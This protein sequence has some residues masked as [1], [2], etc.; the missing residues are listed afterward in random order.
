[1]Q[2]GEIEKDSFW[3]KDSLP[4][5]PQLDTSVKVD[6]IIVGGGIA[7]LH[8][9]YLLKQQGKRVAVI[10]A[11]KIAAGVSG[12]TTAHITS[13]HNLIY[14]Y[15]IE[16]FG[17]DKARTYATANQHALARIAEIITTEEIDCDF[18]RSSQILLT[19]KKSDVEILKKEFD[20]A[21]SLGLPVTY[22]DLVELPFKHY[23][24]IKYQHQ[25]RFHPVK[26]L[27]AIAKKINGDGS[28]IFENSRV[29]DV[30]EGDPCIVITE[31]GE[32]AA[33][34][35][36]I[37]T[38]F[39]I[40]DRGGY[41]AR[42]TAARSYVIGVYIEEKLEYMY[43]D[44]DSPFHYVRNQE[45]DKGT[46]VIVGGED[47]DTGAKSDTEECYK[48][49][50]AYARDHF[51]VKSIAYRWSSQDAYPHD[52]VPFIGKYSPISNHLWVST[53]FN[54]EGMTQSMIGAIVLSDLIDGK[55]NQWADLY[56][57]LRF[58]ATVEGPV[59]MNTG[60]LIAKDEV[61]S[62]IDKIIPADESDKIKELKSN[63]SVVVKIDRDK[64]AAYKDEEGQIHTVSAK[65]G[66]QGCELVFNQAEK[67][68]DCPCHGSRFGID[69]DI[70]HG[71]T[72]R[73]LP[74][75]NVLK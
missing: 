7:G 17:K 32:L 62:T 27:H 24:A 35:V 46:M 68:W 2:T 25:A 47:H 49:L 4:S 73:R 51:T 5:Y 44:T 43:D 21:K 1:M 9:A 61:T 52:K 67:T 15:L 19:E 28:Y 3:L 39:P 18:E 38:N 64:V 48:K 30:K 41:F 75:V 71:P 70:L 59:L 57:P 23:G 50:E 20:A 74:A 69:G 63:Q 8:T 54:G 60:M 29:T 6:V 26:Y 72:V 40:L 33:K 56:S 58:K 34:D 13:E 16:K 31:V 53:G 66:H 10:E 42:M 22:H 11:T 37:A 45:T 12:H 55:E 36:I 14:D 65:C